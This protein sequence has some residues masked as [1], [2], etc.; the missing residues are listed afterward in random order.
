MLCGTFRSGVAMVAAAGLLAG[1]A[2]APGGDSAA[3]VGQ[4]SP[5]TLQRQADFAKDL[6]PEDAEDCAEAERG[7]IARPS[8]QVRAA[9]GR[10][11]KD[12]G[13][14]DFVQGPA[15]DTVNP[16]LWR[17]AQLNAQ[18]GLFKVADGIYQLRGFDMGNIS[19][20]EGKTGWIVVD[21]LTN[22]EIAAYAMAFARQHLGN[23]PVVALVFTHS[24]ADHFGGALGVV[25]A[26]EVAQRKI[27]VVAPAGFM[28]E[29]TSE[30]LLVG[31]AMARRAVYQFGTRLPLSP[32]GNVDTGLGKDLV[33]G[34]MG[35]LQPSISIDRPE[36]ELELDGLRFVFHNMPGAEAPAELTFSLPERKAYGGA[37]ILAR[38]MHNLLPIRGAKVRDALQWSQYL[39][40]V[41]EQTQNAEVLFNQHNWPVWGQSRIAG[42][43][44]RQRDIYKYLHDQTVRLI[45]KGL[46]PG[47][48]AEELKLP[49]ELTAFWG[50]RGYYGDL[51]HNV[52]AIYQFYL[53]SYDGNPANLDPLPPVERA[54][55]Y[56]AAL[57]GAERALAL[58][59]AAE[60]QGDYRWAVELLQ[61]VVFAAPENAQA[62]ELLARSHEQLGYRAESATWRNS[63]LMAAQE[64]RKGVPP[65]SGD[66]SAMAEM[67]A[68]IPTERFLEVMATRLD[69]G[70]AAGQRFS[71]NLAL[72]DVGENYVIWLENSVLHFRRGGPRADA[73]LSLS[74]ARPAFLR[75]LSGG[76]GPGPAAAMKIDGDRTA[77]V[78]FLQLFDGVAADF[79]IV[80]R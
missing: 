71:M 73:D 24:H 25:T 80:T 68:Q 48:I 4:V 12:F 51:R 28:D 5:Q 29:A 63:Y 40:Q 1:C 3:S 2:S 54:R 55:R 72:S 77:L 46:V 32:A 18:A 20:I 36:Q 34:H 10:V 17:H 26:A 76:A 21:A 66:P 56:V 69:A 27:P 44:G 79:P 38:T 8:G 39:Q 22:R 78:R 37:E 23:K 49:P 42:F 41:L 50:G 19:L 65:L 45:N 61:Q 62:K 9:D 31:T 13:A 75:L 7:L 74:L 53:G 33:N 52:K 15:P 64:L 16:S 14:Y 70:R 6:P 60:A 30:N 58:G 47:E 35:I 11:L 59:R 67:I 57:G 43:I